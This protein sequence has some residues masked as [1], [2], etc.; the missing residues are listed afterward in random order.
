MLLLYMDIITLVI[1]ISAL[2]GSIFSHIRHS[3]CSN[4][5]EIDTR[6]PKDNEKKFLLNNS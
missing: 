6:T 3:K 2:V 4:C 5:I 1:A